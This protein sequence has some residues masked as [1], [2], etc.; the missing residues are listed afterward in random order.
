MLRAFGEAARRAVEQR[1]RETDAMF[2][3]AQAALYRQRS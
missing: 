2:Y 3:P 1:N